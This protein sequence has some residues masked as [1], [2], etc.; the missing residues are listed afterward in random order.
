[1]DEAVGCSAEAEDG[2]DQEGDG[3]PERQARC[4]ESQRCEEN[5]FSFFFQFVQIIFQVSLIQ[6]QEK[7]EKE[8]TQAEVTSD[9]NC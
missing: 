7:L 8:K 4:P 1:M 9:F 2:A 3:S 6:M 5:F